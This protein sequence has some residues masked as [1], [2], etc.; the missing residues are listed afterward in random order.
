MEKINM[1]KWLKD[2]I[3]ADE[4]K[5]MPVLSF[6][7]VQLLGISVQELISDSDMQA[8]GMKAVADRTDMAAAL[9]YMDLSVEA[10]AFGSHAVFSEDEVPTITGK[11]ITTME[12][13]ENLRVPQVGEGRTGTYIEG[14]AKA[15]K[16]ISDKPLLAGCIGPFSLAGRLMDVTEA[17]V[18]CYIEPDMVHKTLEKATA[19]LIDYIKAYKEAGAN[20]AV[21]A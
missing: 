1:K 20:G 7:A 14:V 2:M 15:S 10:E 16:I 6:P 13:A 9:S 12:D 5:A 8:K 3:A 11:I 18:N 17:M 4:K 21:M 19:F